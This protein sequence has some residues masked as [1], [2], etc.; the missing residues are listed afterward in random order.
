MD[1]ETIYHDP[2]SGA[3]LDAPPPHFPD[4]VPVDQD[5]IQYGQEDQ[6]N[7]FE[8]EALPDIDSTEYE[9]EYL[10]IPGP[11]L[12]L[13][14]EDEPDPFLVEHPPQSTPNVQQIPDH[15]LAIY[16]T[17]SWL[18]LQFSLPRV[19]CNALLLILAHL[20][21]FFDPALITPFIT[22]QSVTRTLGLDPDIQVLPV[23]PNCREVYPSATSKH[24]QEACTTCKVGLFRSD[25]TRQGNQ[26]IARLP[27]VKYPYLLLS[28]QIATVLKVPGVEALLDEWRKKPR[29]RGEYT[30]IFDGN[31]CRLGLK[32]PDGN[33]FF[34]NLPNKNNGPYGELRIGVNLGVDWC[35]HS[36]KFPALD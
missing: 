30:D 20:L 7:P 10:T 2:V 27:I 17:V 22:L 12:S 26:R 6:E 9:E 34:S 36:I 4:Q 25:Q 15:L 24:V 31:V 8:E 33:L 28:E 5:L 23:C 3:R 16:A 18:H 32:A 13:P 35:V 11:L 14:S 21:T 19:A 29:S 1:Q